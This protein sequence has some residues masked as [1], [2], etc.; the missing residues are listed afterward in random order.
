MK[1]VALVST[2]I[3]FVALA[4]I[5]GPV[6]NEEAKYQFDQIAHVRYTLESEQ[7]NTFVKPISPPNKDF[8]IAIPKINATAAI[9]DNKAGRL[10]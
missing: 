7:T 8:S 6:I 9:I 10:T 5:F 3:T 1:Y 4:T 2:F